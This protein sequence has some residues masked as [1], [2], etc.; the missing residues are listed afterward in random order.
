MRFSEIGHEAYTAAADKRARLNQLFNERAALRAQLVEGDDETN[1]L[2]I[3]KLN[4]LD[5]VI[6]SLEETMSPLAAA[7]TRLAQ[8]KADLKELPQN[9]GSQ[10]GYDALDDL[11]DEIKK[12]EAKIASL[13]EAA[14]G[15]KVRDETN[16][17][18]IAFEKAQLRA[19]TALGFIRGAIDAMA[20]E[21]QRNSRDWGYP[22]SMAQIAKQLEE[23]REFLG[24]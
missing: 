17:P 14:P 6:N 15:P 13:S 16:D 20:E 12:Q 19:I 1:Q 4:R 5:D 11:R 24:K 9:P 7:K 22:G 23:I 2:L 3:A 21:Q 18:T 10:E 8:L